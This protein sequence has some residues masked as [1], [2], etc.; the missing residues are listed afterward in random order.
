VKKYLLLLLLALPVKQ[1]RADLWGADIPLLVEIVT[2]TL[3]TLVELFR[4]GSLLGD[5][6]EGIKDRI[7]RI[8]TIS[9]LVQPS[10]WDQWKD[11]REALSRLQRIYYTLPPEYRSEKSDSIEFEISRAMN[12]IGRLQPQ[13]ATTFR[14][15]KEL[16]A[17]GL[18]A[19]PGVA[20]KLTASGVGT[21]V[22][23]QAQSQELQSQMVSLLSQQLAQANENESRAIVSHGQ[24]FKAVSDNLGAQ[25]GLFSTHVKALRVWR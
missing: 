17:R 3:G 15:G 14:S 2:N 21:L 5:E 4:Q 6:L 24:N 7:G 8:Q 12:L 13:S 19:S 20:Q 25:D 1:A 22:S 16:E 9:E 18:T 23:L 10:Q 11:P